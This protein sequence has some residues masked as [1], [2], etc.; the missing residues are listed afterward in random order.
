MLEAA[1][2][3]VMDM[4]CRSMCTNYLICDYAFIRVP[5]SMVWESCTSWALATF[6]RDAD[7]HSKMQMH[8][9]PHQGDDHM[10]DALWGYHSQLMSLPQFFSENFTL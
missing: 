7:L 1:D 2:C 8:N 3:L 4:E 5:Q 9:I 6:I 10:G